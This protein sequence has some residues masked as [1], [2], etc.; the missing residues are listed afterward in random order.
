[1]NTLFEVNFVGFAQHQKSFA[2]TFLVLGLTPILLV[3][4]PLPW[5]VESIIPKT[6]SES[7]KITAKSPLGSQFSGFWR[8]DEMFYRAT[9]E[10]FF[11]V[12]P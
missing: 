3:N 9:L 4:Y 8:K 6:P 12:R 10:G 5:S 11:G 2:Q 7:N 1:M